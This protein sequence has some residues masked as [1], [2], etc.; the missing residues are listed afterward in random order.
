MQEDSNNKSGIQVVLEK[1]RKLFKRE[2]QKYYSEKHYR[3]AERKFLKYVLGQ[4][5]TEIQGTL[6]PEE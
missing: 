1:A 2:N 6:T 3:S 5:T 4:R